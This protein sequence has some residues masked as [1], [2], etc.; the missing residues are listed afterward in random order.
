MIGLPMPEWIVRE[1]RREDAEGFVRAHEAAW[2]ATGLVE[3]RLGDLVPFEERVRVFEAGVEK[4]SD[5]AWVWVAERD[6]TII[7]LAVC[8]RADEI[9]ELRDLY[10]VPEAWGSGVAA[11]L[12][13]TALAWMRS[14]AREAILWVGEMNARARRFYEREGWQVDGE[15]RT[16]SLGP[17]ELRYRL[18][19]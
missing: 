16:S 10:V 11:A 2:D 12:H 18:T 6:G 19:F 8:T 3:Q 17:P 9:A 5:D 7:G 13:E 4:V 14:R 1:A 15:R